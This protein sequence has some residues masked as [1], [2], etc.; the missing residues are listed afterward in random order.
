MSVFARSLAIVIF[1][2]FMNGLEGPARAADAIKPT[3]FAI[4]FST[5]RGYW[6]VEDAAGR[7]VAKDECFTQRQCREVF[8]TLVPGAYTLVLSHEPQSLPLKFQVTASGSLEITSGKEVLA[9]AGTTLK[10][11]GLRRVLFN[12][13]GYRGVWSLANWDGAEATGFFRRD[14]GEQSIELVPNT[15][16][17]LKIGPVIV[18][19]FQVDNAERV[20]LIDGRGALTL[21]PDARNKLVLA[22]LPVAIYPALNSETAQWTLAGVSPPDGRAAFRGPQVLRLAQGTT[23]KLS[24]AGAPPSDKPAEFSTG[25]G[26]SMSNQTVKTASAVV[27]VSPVAAGCR[28]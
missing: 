17:A 19:R 6:R 4:E 10:L 22:T 5:Y 3:R 25:K 26:C 11:S 20:V 24:V 16:Y 27:H 13:D 28:D 23:Y 12:L 21:S 15:T 8:K 9:V 18:E 2:I 1:S 7:A 14:G